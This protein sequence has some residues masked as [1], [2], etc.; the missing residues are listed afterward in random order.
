[1]AWKIVL[2]VAV[3]FV[4]ITVYSIVLANRCIKQ[5]DNSNKI[6]KGMDEI[7]VLDLMGKDHMTKTF[8]ENDNSNKYVWKINPPKNYRGVREVTVICKN[9]KAISKTSK[10]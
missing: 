10:S 4:L 1:M 8:D 3:L 5:M 7:E 9:G 6:V 2:A